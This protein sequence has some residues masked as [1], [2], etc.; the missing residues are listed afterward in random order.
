[1]GR[2]DKRNSEEGINIETEKEKTVNE[3]TALKKTKTNK[4]KNYTQKQSHQPNTDL[5]D[6]M[7]KS[8]DIFL[9]LAAGVVILRPQPLAITVAPRPLLFPRA[10]R[11][12][13]CARW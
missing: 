4:K 12:G 10:A 1:M 9:E 7:Q 11:V 13:A 5:V 3:V 8:C 6:D 2:R